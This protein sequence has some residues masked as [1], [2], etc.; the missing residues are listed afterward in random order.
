MAI[1]GS[2]LKL[3]FSKF[4]APNMF[5]NITTA[6][7]EHSQCRMSHKCS[8]NTSRGW[9]KFHFH[10]ELIAPS[11]ASGAIYVY[12]DSAKKFT[13]AYHTHV[14]SRFIIFAHAD[15]QLVSGKHRQAWLLNWWGVLLIFIL[16]I[17][18]I[19]FD[20]YNN[21]SKVFWLWFSHWF[22]YLW[23]INLHYDINDGTVD[24]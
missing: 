1:P 12:A 7:Y 9:W 3:H 21:I 4:S 14:W 5:S 24:I 23:P 10:G 8:S 20:A 11:L 22:N 15:P 6:F 2:E 19:T 13:H 16:N 17:R 18:C